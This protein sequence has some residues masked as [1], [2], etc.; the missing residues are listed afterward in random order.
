MNILFLMK[1]FEIG[2]QEVVTA[3]LAKPFVDH[4]HNVSI[5]V[6]NKPNPQ[7][8]ARLDTRV[9][10]YTIGEFRYTESNVRKLRKILIQEKAD[11]VINQ[12]GLPYVP[13]KVLHKARKGLGI[14]TIAVYHNS[15][16]SNAR[17]KGVELALEHTDNPLKRLLLFCKMFAFKQI[18]SCSMRYVYYHSDLY[19]V[20]SPSFIDKFKCFTGIKNP[21]HLVVQTNP[22]TIDVSGY[23]FS[24][25]EKQKEV[26]YVGRIDHNQKRVRRII[27]AWTL[28]EKQY[29]EWRLTIVGDGP[30]RTNLERLVETERLKNVFFEGFKTPE[31]YYKRAS[32]LTLSS[33]YEGF[34][35][36]IVEAMS[37]GVVPVVLGSYS[38][39]YDIL[40]D[41][42]NGFILPYDK[43]VGFNAKDMAG[44]MAWLMKHKDEREAIAY[45]AFVSSKRFDIE[46]IGSEWNKQ[47]NN[48]YGVY[49]P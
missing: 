41:G 44:R 39:V 16:D 29:P 7:M 23:N 3:T 13:A 19:M 22:V 33:E 25:E 4:G 40:E 14:K 35:L 9:K 15:P 8:V 24:P 30:E 31:P 49:M 17:L 18:T 10:V 5:A 26:L 42:K 48:V 2:G 12:W 34:G 28:L 27:D 6:F 38:A 20:L 36:V 47:L 46:K 45:D 1:V 11:I 21:N 37:Y 43:A 32:I